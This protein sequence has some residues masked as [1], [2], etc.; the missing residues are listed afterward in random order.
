M[1]LK[2]I[3]GKLGQAEAIKNFL[4][5]EISGEEVKTALWRVVNKTTEVVKVGSVEEWQGNDAQV[6]VGAVDKSLSLALEGTTNEPDEVVFGLQETWVNEEGI[7]A[8]RKPIL[9]VL[10]EKLDL[11][12]VGFVV[13]T[14]AISH[15]L[16][17]IEGGP[18]SAIL[19]FVNKTEVVV[20]VVVQSKMVGTQVV[21]RSERLSDDVEEGLA[22]FSGVESLPARMIIY[23]GG[24]DME[25]ARQG[26]LNHEWQ[27]KL[28]FLHFPKVEVMEKDASV[29]AVAVAGGAEVAKS[30]GLE[31]T[32]MASMDLGDGG[33]EENEIL[34]DKV[35]ETDS[36]T[37]TAEDFGFEKVVTSDVVETPTVEV[38]NQEVESEESLGQEFKTMDNFTIGDH[39]VMVSKGDQPQR[40]EGEEGALEESSG[41]VRGKL[42][43]F[44]GGV[45]GV[46]GKFRLPW[47]GKL[48]KVSSWWWIGGGLVVLLMIV[49]GLVYWNVPKAKVMIYLSPRVVEKTM[50][51][52][53]DPEAR[54]L[55]A[56]ELVLP[57]EAREVE[58]DG[59]RTIPT[60]GEA[61]VG[62]RASGVV[63]VFNRT[64]SSRTLEAGTELTLD[65]LVFT[66]DE[67]V[68]IA[69]ASSEEN[70][71]FTTTIV[72]SSEDVSVS[73]SDIGD[74]YNLAGDTQ[75]SVADFATSSF[76]ARVNSGL[77]GGFA[78]QIRAVAEE[79]LEKLLNDLT[80]ELMRKA[81]DEVG[82]EKSD[83][84][85]V[86]VTV[87]QE[88][89]DEE[90]SGD[91]GDEGDEL[92]L[93]LKLRLPIY[94]Y[95]V[96]DLRLLL[97]KEYE[98]DI[99]DEFRLNDDDIEIVV[100]EVDLND[101]L[102]LV[103][104]VVKM[105]L[106]PDLD[107][108]EIIA[109][110]RGKYPAL[111]EDYFRSIP[112]FSKVD[113]EFNPGLPDRIKTFPKKAGNI[114]VEVMV[115]D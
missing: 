7:T 98:S 62:E 84:E 108:Q 99:P 25:V 36:A 22:R 23:D 95:S 113:T 92:S 55:N 85:A 114:T 5:I 12:P 105:K 27:K 65:N 37:E 59:E 71:D 39:E 69:S 46:F 90:Y 87:G 57:A 26:L 47:A 106:V 107:T 1:E 75:L 2:N 17:S 100:E 52:T 91:E 43:S 72:P 112:N 61:L 34:E 110:I 74:E 28:S 54:V 33:A 3:F 94:L 88:I 8:G 42:A 44:L 103:G 97:E 111:T 45:G 20:T 24:E 14:E 77:S 15:Y 89:V 78:R 40:I 86:V 93:K 70:D 41:G 29:R 18:V 58:V 101:N 73:A 66:L 56:E 81:V 32:G 21:G 4:A 80:E 115:E 83:R 109:V 96:G 49:L 13:T 10:T 64:E 9:K 63:K 67:A 68:T 31:V 38:S 102:V 19:L 76:V 48:G 16:S 6:L 104:A 82:N 35:G 11:K 51:F 60:T 30:Q 50:E 79:D 53:L